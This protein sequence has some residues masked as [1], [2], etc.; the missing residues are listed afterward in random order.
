VLPGK[1]ELNYAEWR[2]IRLI[3]DANNG[4]ALWPECPDCDTP[5]ES[6]PLKY[7][8]IGMDGSETAAVQATVNEYNVVHFSEFGKNIFEF[9]AGYNPINGPGVYIQKSGA[10]TTAITP[11][12]ATSAGAISGLNKIGQPA[13]FRYFA[14]VEVNDSFDDQIL[15]HELQR[16]VVM[17]EGTSLNTAIRPSSTF[18]S[19]GAA[20]IPLEDVIL[21]SNSYRLFHQVL[22]NRDNLGGYQ[23]DPVEN[24]MYREN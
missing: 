19:A 7:N 12:N 5:V 24:R 13:E 8:I 21:N 20:S 11:H 18:N 14:R 22:K 23:F 4:G 9:D 1:D 3:N 17:A 6:F 2:D 10:N 16:A 15:T